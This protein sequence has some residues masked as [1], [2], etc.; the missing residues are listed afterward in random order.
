MLDKVR[1]LTLT[2]SRSL[3]LSFSLALIITLSCSLTL[4]LSLA[5]SPF[6]ALHLAP[7]FS[8]APHSTSL[9]L[10]LP[11]SLTPSRNCSDSL[12]LSLFHPLAFVSLLFFLFTPLLSSPLPSLYISISF[13]ISFFPVTL[14]NP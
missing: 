13:F 6:V 5:P 1:S 3:P 11:R 8:L 9:Y 14:K 7:S 10:A 2:P 4:S 12:S